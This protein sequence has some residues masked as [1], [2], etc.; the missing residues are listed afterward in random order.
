[1]E[2][3]QLY[4]IIKNEIAKKRELKIR[5]LA[6]SYTELQNI[7]QMGVDEIKH[8]LNG[9]YIIGMIEVYKSIND[10]MITLKHEESK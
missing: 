5:P 3:P 10:K 4:D 9:L 2:K 8:Q 1:M 6:I 7:A